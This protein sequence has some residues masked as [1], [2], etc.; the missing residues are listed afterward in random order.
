MLY[1][2]N[3]QTVKDEHCAF[4]IAALSLIGD[5]ED[6]QDSLGYVLRQDEGI[7]VVADGMGGYEGG[8]TASELAVKTF[9]SQYDENH[10][11]VNQT[12]MMIA[13]AKKTDELIAG[14]KNE[15]GGLLKAGSTVVSIS[16]NRRKL[17]WCSVGDSRG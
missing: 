1:N 14:L 16:I 6:Q 13:T 3:G 17:M 4:Q 9:L 12:E 5:R 8:K 11:S 7:I 2:E 15:N 10:S